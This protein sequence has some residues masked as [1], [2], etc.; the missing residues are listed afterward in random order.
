MQADRAR[1]DARRIWSRVFDVVIEL[2]E[3]EA[4]LVAAKEDMIR[5]LDASHQ[6]TLRGR[7]LVLERSLSDGSV[8]DET[9]AFSA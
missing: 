7:Q 8:F 4:A 5:T 1:E 3:L 9:D 6:R 2:A